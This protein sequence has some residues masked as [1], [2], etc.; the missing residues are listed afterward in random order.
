M[1]KPSIPARRSSHAASTS[2]SI[3]IVP[4]RISSSKRAKVVSGESQTST[5]QDLEKKVKNLQE[6]TKQRTL[7]LKKPRLSHD[8]EFYANCANA[9][10]LEIE[11][12]A[13]QIDLGRTRSITSGSE[14]TWE[15]SQAQRDLLVKIEALTQKRKLLRTSYSSLD[16]KSQGKNAVIRRSYLELLLNA[17]IGFDLQ[18]N[19][20]AGKRNSQ[21][22]KNFRSQLI[23]CYGLKPT[24]EELANEPF[25]KDCVWDVTIGDFED[26]CLFKDA[27]LF[28][29][30]N[31][32]N[33]MSAIFG[34]DME[35]E[36][37]SPRNGLMI[38]YRLE[39]EFESGLIA[40]VPDMPRNATK[41]EFH[42]WT[43]SEP[44]EYIFRILEGS[45]NGHEIPATKDFCL[46]NV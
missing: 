12:T 19:Q 28:P 1:S 4:G 37:F 36:L 16:A 11:H 43:I 15:D 24:V 14:E 5:I 9:A 39:R 25:L 35:G 29:W 31:G 41:K 22:Q 33:T 27:H 45:Y 21:A 23:E 46:T 34:A 10:T 6:E 40:I 38:P 3:S 20:Y 2:A 32:T 18:K 17:S 8:P 13:S 26:A 42:K 7:Q 44:K 30:R